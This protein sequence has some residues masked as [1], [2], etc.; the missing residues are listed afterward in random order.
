MSITGT[1]EQLDDNIEE[2]ST[3]FCTLYYPQRIET[4]W[5]VDYILYLFF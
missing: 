1:T 2:H 5:F 3:S 4:T